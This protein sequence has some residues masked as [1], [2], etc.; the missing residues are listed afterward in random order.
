MGQ[1]LGLAQAMLRRPTVLI[2]DEPTNVI[3]TAVIKEL[4][5]YLREIAIEEK[6]Q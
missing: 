6:L 4:R 2:L 3:D 5:D 1:R